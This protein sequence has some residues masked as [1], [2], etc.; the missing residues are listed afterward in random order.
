MVGGFIQQEQIRACE[1]HPCKGDPLLLPAGKLPRLCIQRADSQAMTQAVYAMLHIPA[2]MQILP[3]LQFLLLP[4][5]GLCPHR[6]GIFQ[7]RTYPAEALLACIYRFKGLAQQLNYS[8]IAIKICFLSQIFDPG[9][10]GVIDISVIRILK[11][12]NNFQQGGLAAA[13]AS[14]QPDFLFISHGKADIAQ[15]FKGSIA[16]ADRKYIHNVQNVSPE[17]L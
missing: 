16:F 1:Q 14:D 13:I 3:A 11:S 10:F 2:S 8:Q 17:L 9:T 15:Q 12:G 7:F 4:E 6:I 5:Q